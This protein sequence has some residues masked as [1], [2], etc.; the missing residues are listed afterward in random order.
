MKSKPTP[1]PVLVSES[2]SLMKYMVHNHSSRD[3]EQAYA[4]SRFGDRPAAIV[5][6]MTQVPH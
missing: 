5:V 6:E 4:R 1:A 3:E 2:T